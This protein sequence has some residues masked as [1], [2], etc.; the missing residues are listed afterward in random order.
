MLPIF[1]ALGGV[2]LTVCEKLFLG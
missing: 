1:L 2:A